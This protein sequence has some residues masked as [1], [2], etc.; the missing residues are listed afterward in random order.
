[1][2]IPSDYPKRIKDLRLRL[3]LTQVV[4]AEKLGV[5][6]ATVNRWENS[7]TK[8]SNL[9]WVMILDMEKEMRQDDCI[10]ELALRLAR[11]LSSEGN[12]L[13]DQLIVALADKVVELQNDI[14]R[15]E[16]K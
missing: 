7:Q 11:G 9:A 4:L 3:G 13:R 1:M 8:P 6:F 14:S 16:D 2:T 10:K 12:Y 5:S 15:L